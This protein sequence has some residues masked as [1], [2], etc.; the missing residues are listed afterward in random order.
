MMKFKLAKFALLCYIS[1][2]KKREPES[3]YHQI[4][5]SCMLGILKAESSLHFW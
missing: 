3:K 4:I 5:A 1:H 2:C